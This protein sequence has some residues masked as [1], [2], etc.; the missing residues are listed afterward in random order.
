MEEE[1]RNS[2]KRGKRKQHRLPYGAK[3]VDGGY[4][5]NGVFYTDFS[6]ELGK[7][8]IRTSLLPKL[9]FVFSEKY[10][11]FDT[12]LR[13][14]MDVEGY[15]PVPLLLFIPAI[16]SFEVDASFLMEVLA[17]SSF[18]E[19]DKTRHTVRPKVN[20]EK[21]ILP[22]ANGEKGVPRYPVITEV[23]AQQ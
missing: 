16:Q 19:V 5:L 10:L 9:E 23:I 7:R 21:W 11:S 6:S 4:V 2:N 3:A 8:M 17:D 12:F 1:P 14:Y 22:N 15:F 18:A 20:W 13:P